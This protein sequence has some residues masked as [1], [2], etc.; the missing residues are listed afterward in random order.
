MICNGTQREYAQECSNK[1][2]GFQGIFLL[3]CR[4]H[5][6]LGNLL[7]TK[8]KRAERER[9]SEWER[10]EAKETCETCRTC[11]VNVG[12]WLFAAGKE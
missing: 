5:V 1:E 10:E 7:K 8:L 12:N 3:A 6:K 4:G 11:M 2:L 9:D